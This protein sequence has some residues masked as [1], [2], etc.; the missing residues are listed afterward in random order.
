MP[1]DL[2]PPTRL[3]IPPQETVRS[4]DPRALSCGSRGGLKQCSRCGLAQD[5]TNFHRRTLSRDGLSPKCKA[6]SKA[7]GAARYAAHKPRRSA[8]NAAWYAANRDV[9]RARTAAWCLANPE[10]AAAARADWQRKNPEKVAVRNKKWRDDN[11]EMQR[12][13]RKRRYWQNPERAIAKVQRRHAV[14]RGVAAELVTLSE[15]IARDGTA[16]YICGRSTDPKAPYKSEL[17][18]HLEHVIP[19]AS[20]GT[21]TKDNLRCACR[22][23][24]ILKGGFRTPGETARILGLL[25]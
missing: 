14:T 10:R 12:A 20:G 7:A 23:C 6:C 21:H 1:L 2:K 4:L 8:Q 22:R 25:P 24:N 17:K 3:D 13:G 9:V 18:A 15:I 5:L 16:C 19:L 11:L